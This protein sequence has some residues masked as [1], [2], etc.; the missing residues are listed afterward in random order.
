MT[1]LLKSSLLQH[2]APNERQQSESQKMTTRMIWENTYLEEQKSAVVRGSEE[3]FNHAVDARPQAAHNHQHEVDQSSKWANI[4][5][6]QIHRSLAPNISH[7]IHARLANAAMT[8]AQLPSQSAAGNVMLNYKN[9]HRNSVRNLVDYQLVTKFQNIKLPNIRI[10]ENEEVVKIYLRS[11]EKSIDRQKLIEQ[12]KEL[13]AKFGKQLGQITL[14]G[15]VVWSNNA[16]TLSG[17]G[18]KSWQ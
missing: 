8:P 9:I 18:E 16:N 15:E 4:K 2:F 14:N 5:N 17:K 6:T 13:F 1:E 3:E 12:L 11:H 10:I 7:S